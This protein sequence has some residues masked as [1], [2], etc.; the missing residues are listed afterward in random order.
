MRLVEQ[1]LLTLPDHMNSPRSL[2]GFVLLNRWF[3][4]VMHSFVD[5][6]L[7]FCFGH[8]ILCPSLIDGFYLTLWYF[9]TF[10]KLGICLCYHGLIICNMQDKCYFFSIPMS[11]FF[12]VVISW[13]YGLK[14][15]GWKL[16]EDGKFL[17]SNRLFCVAEAGLNILIYM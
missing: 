17:E 14:K 13:F 12:L 7:F 6:C 2:V 15:F 4:C 5:H 9:H 8:C 1:E 16:Y 11:N 10:L 3:V